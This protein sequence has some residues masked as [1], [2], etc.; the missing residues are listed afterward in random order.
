LPQVVASRGLGDA[1]DIGAVLISRIQHEACRF[2]SGK[3]GGE[4]NLIAGLIPAAGGPMAEEM[5][6]ALRERAELIEARAQTLA[7]SE[8]DDEATWVKRLG[9]PPDDDTALRRWTREV[10]TVAAYRD[11][12][13]ITT[14]T[15]LG[16]DP[17][18]QAQRRDA[19][20]AEQAIR[21]ARAIAREAVGEPA[22]GQVL[23]RGASIA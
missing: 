5:S 2:R 11:R 8:I 16:D 19:G 21:R 7:R 20:R 13:G 6:A 10:G 18:T 17:K 12:Y 1:V 14:R 15:V 3:R 9:T 4:P 23:R 22:R